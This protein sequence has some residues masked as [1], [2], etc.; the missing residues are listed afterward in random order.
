MEANKRGVGLHAYM[1]V[2]DDMEATVKAGAADAE[3]KKKLDTICRNIGDQVRN[4]SS[5]QR[6]RPVKPK[7]DPNEGVEYIPVRWIGEK[8]SDPLFR[9]KADKWY[10][11]AVD[12]LTPEQRADPQI[13]RKL[14]DQR[15]VIYKEMSESWKTS[16]NW[17]PSRY[18]NMNQ[19]LHDLNY[20]TPPRNYVPDAG[21]EPHKW[22][23]STTKR[24]SSDRY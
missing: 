12:L 10:N 18:K 20:K 2:W 13:R 4:S 8:G 1:P 21:N 22:N 15:D 11:N 16:K 23:G 5:I 14:H 6:F 7:P 19:D 3:V 9:D 17:A 24:G